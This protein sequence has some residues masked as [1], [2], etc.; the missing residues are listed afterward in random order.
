MSTNTVSLP[1]FSLAERDRRFRAV[2]E[3]MA[4]QGLDLLLAPHN[5]GDWDNYQPDV[6]YLTQIGGNG[7]AAAVVFPLEGEAIA[8]ARDAGRVDWWKRAQTWVADVRGTRAAHWS[9]AL[10]GAVR[11][12]GGEAATIAVVGLADVLRDPEG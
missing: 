7:T 2:R 3:Q 11:D 12:L 8:I 4:V 9:E 5:T 6:R 10:I 1:Q